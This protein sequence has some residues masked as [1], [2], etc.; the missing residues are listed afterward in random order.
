MGI[1]VESCTVSDA[2]GYMVK[3]RLR[4]MCMERL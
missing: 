1:D 4:E 3:H 2:M